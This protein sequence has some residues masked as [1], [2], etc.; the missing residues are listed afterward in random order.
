MLHAEGIVVTL[1]ADHFIV[2]YFAL[3]IR[4]LIMPHFKVA[5]KGQTAELIRFIEGSGEWA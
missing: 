3:R 4:E 1:F 2:S 5:G